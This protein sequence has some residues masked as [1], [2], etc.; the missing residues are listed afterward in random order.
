[1][2]EGHDVSTCQPENARARRGKGSCVQAFDDPGVR[3]LRSKAIRSHDIKDERHLKTKGTCPST[4]MPFACLRPAGRSSSS[5]SDESEIQSLAAL[6]G[7]LIHIFATYLD[8]RPFQRSRHKLM[9]WAG[10]AVFPRQ[11]FVN[12][13][14]RGDIYSWWK[15]TRSGERQISIESLTIC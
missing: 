9:E 11:S 7:S 15:A 2:V 10:T 5:V 8:S 12:A 6:K 13:L 1:M 4:Q 3:F 14:E